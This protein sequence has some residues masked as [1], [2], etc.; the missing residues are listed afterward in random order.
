LGQDFVKQLHKRGITIVL[1]NPSKIVIKQIARAN[2]DKLIGPGNIVVRTADAV[3]ICKVPCLLSAQP[4]CWG[5]FEE[6]EGFSV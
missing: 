1:A 2:L 6:V 5:N 4:P 3:E